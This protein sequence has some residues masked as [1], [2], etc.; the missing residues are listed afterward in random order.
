MS[1]KKNM[2]GLGK[3]PERRQAMYQAIN[4]TGLNAKNGIVRLY[5][6]AVGQLIH[7]QRVVQAQGQAEVTQAAGQVVLHQDV[8]ALY[9]PVSDGH[10]VA[11]AGGVVA[12]KV[13]HS[14]R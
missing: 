6:P 9:V 13:S 2:A 10:F 4:L 14:E 7:R 3:C 1:Y 5:L 12:V 8:G 11:T